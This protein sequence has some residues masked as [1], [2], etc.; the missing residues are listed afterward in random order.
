MMDRLP[1]W[2]TVPFLSFLF[3]FSSSFLDP[4]RFKQTMTW[5]GQILYINKQ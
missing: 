2:E 1:V 4:G 5:D 3:L